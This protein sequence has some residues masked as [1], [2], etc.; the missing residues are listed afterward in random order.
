MSDDSVK[1]DLGCGCGIVV[2]AMSAAFVILCFKAG[3]AIIS[4]ALDI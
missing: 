2:L 3:L 1:V 4:W